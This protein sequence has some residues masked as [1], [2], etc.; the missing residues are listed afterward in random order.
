MKPIGQNK[1]PEY[2]SNLVAF[3]CDD[4]ARMLTLMRSTTFPPSNRLMA[5]RFHLEQNDG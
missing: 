5:H 3:E 4:M 1:C 2:G